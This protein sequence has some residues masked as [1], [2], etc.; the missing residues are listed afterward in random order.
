MCARANP[1]ARA[2]ASPIGVPGISGFP[3]RFA[4]F[5]SRNTGNN[6]EG[7]ERILHVF[8]VLLDARDSFTSGHSLRTARLAKALV[9]HMKLS[10]EEGAVAY[11]AGLVHDCGRVGVPIEVVDRPGRLNEQELNLVREHAQMTIRTLGCIPDCPGM[12]ELGNI[13][14][15]DHERWDGRGHPDH[16]SGE[17]IPLISRVLSVVDAFDAMTA[18]TTYRML[19]PKCAVMRLKDGSGTQFDPQVVDAMISAL[20]SG[21]LDAA[22]PRAA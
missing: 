19:S 16:L 17:N 11:R 12:A 1:L 21:A 4:P 2:H 7:V 8:A 3:F 13:A 18:T 5:K 10:E 9:Q 15:H 22:T 6:E 14:G 20:E